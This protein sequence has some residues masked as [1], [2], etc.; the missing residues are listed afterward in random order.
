MP[1][2]M[3]N[4]GDEIQNQKVEVPKPNQSLP[5]TKPRWKTILKVRKKYWNIKTEII[6]QTSYLINDNSH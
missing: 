6:Y 5:N 3:K 1:N 4:A 2:Q